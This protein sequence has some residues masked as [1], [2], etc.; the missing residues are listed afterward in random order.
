M[1]AVISFSCAGVVRNVQKAFKDSM[2]IVYFG[3]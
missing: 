1:R 2:T 3:G